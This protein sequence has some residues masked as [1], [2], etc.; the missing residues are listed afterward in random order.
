MDLKTINKKIKRVKSQLAK[1]CA[2]LKMLEARKVR[3]ENEQISKVFRQSDITIVE[4][5]ELLKL[6]KEGKADAWLSQ[7]ISQ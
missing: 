7:K 4:L 2:K 1:E 5:D 3:L 6:R